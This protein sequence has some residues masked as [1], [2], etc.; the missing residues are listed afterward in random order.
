MRHGEEKRAGGEAPH[1]ARRRREP[2][3]ARPASARAPRRDWRATET[4]HP[5]DIAFLAR[6]GVPDRVLDLAARLATMRGTMPSQE[7]F[8]AALDPRRYWS[9]LAADLGLAFAENFRGATLEPPATEDAAAL[10]RANSALL[11]TGE[12]IVLVVAP[13]PDEIEPLRRRLREAPALVA[14]LRI[15]APGTIRAYIA[16]ERQAA[17]RD[18]AVN[19]LAAALPQ[20]SAR[21]LG[22]SN[23]AAGPKALL[24]AALGLFLLAPATTFSA[25]G[26]LC[27]LFF[28][29]CSVWKLAAA[30]GRQRRRRLE[31]VAS[32]RLPTYTVLVPLYREAAMVSDLVAHL[33]RIDYPALCISSTC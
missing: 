30:F 25:L 18:R 23:G 2:L 20:L 7:L 9:A 32:A 28:C 11:R 13:G 22:G 26:L 14:R 12:G 21:H 6:H 24:A 33:A 3:L 16:R 29:N 19:G 1:A 5:P 15:A 27:T 31:P 17:F 8:S 10:R 4:A